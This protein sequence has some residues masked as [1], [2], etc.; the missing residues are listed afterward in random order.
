MHGLKSLSICT[1]VSLE[2]YLIFKLHFS[3]PFNC[4]IYNRLEDTPHAFNATQKVLFGPVRTLL[5]L[6]RFPASPFPFTIW[7]FAYEFESARAHHCIQGV[8]G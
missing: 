2:S 8:R 6:S 3:V 1:Q 5:V 7:E 4:L